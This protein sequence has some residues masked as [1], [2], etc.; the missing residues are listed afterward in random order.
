M[1]AQNLLQLWHD[2][3]A[4]G[5]PGIPPEELLPYLG[6]AAEGIDFLNT[7]EPAVIHRDVK[8]EH[9]LL[10]A[11]G[12]VKVAGPGPGKSAEGTNAAVGP[13]Q[14]GMT[15]AYAA[16]EL[17]ANTVTRWTDQYSLA[18][19]YYRLR[20]G[21]LPF[22]DGLG[23]MQIMQAHA[24]GTLDFAAVPTAERAVL[25]RACAVEP[26]RRFPSCGEF[27]AALQAA[28]AG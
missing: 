22:A 13:A 20:T 24:N 9:L 18:L 8:P 2:H 15:L 23:P 11:D 3:H 1:A 4:Q 14:V 12:R 27:V 7:R 25:K 28:V 17:F 6:Q 5:R 19:T 26:D 10:T 21:K 16:P